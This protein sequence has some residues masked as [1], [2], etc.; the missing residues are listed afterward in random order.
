[1]WV[2]E[3]VPTSHVAANAVAGNRDKTVTAAITIAAAFLKNCLIF[4]VTSKSFV[5]FY[6]LKKKFSHVA[7]ML[8]T[9]SLMQEP[10]ISFF[11]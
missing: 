3:I 1:V 9:S 11:G 8:H 7:L 10:H 6:R 2:K 4:I 5:V